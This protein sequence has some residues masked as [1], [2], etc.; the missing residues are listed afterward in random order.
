MERRFRALGTDCHLVI[1]GGPPG[2]GRDAEERV[3]EIERRWSRF[4]ADS[5]VSCLNRALGKPV[6]VSLDTMRLIETAAAAWSA[7]G[8]RFDPTVIDSLVALGY[9]RA[10]REKG[11]GEQRATPHP[12]PG[13]AGIEVDRDART[14]RLPLGVRFDPGGIGKGLAA[15]IVAGE[16]WANGA[17][18][19]V[20]NLGGDVRVLGRPVPVVVDEPLSGAAPC[21]V[22]VE[23]GAVATSTVLR[24]RWT[25]ASG[26][27]HHVIDPTTGVSASGRWNVATV[28]AGTAWWAEAVTLSM[29]VGGFDGRL[30]VPWRLVDREGSVH[31]GGGFSA[32]ER[33]EV[34]HG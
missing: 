27:V 10:Y 33:T 7:T 24:R 18:L 2:A 28:I 26:D 11:F 22:V 30:D 8:G 32:F 1:E 20:V 21:Q 14:V 9:D 29:L 12:S 17:E 16:L 23:N 3:G 34:R 25:T 5:D 31:T 15:D 6:E 4:I 19:V 13:C